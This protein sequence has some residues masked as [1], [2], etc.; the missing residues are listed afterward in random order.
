MPDHDRQPEGRAF[1]S[2]PTGP[3]VAAP[4][5]PWAAPPAPY[6]APPSPPVRKRRSYW[7]LLLFVL[8]VS[9]VGIR[10]YRDLSSPEAWSYWK[11]Q[12]V[13]PSLNAQPVATV[14]LDGSVRRV[15]ALAISGTIG[16]AAADWFRGQ[17][18][19]NKLAAGDVI[20]LSSPGGDLAQGI[21]IGEAIRARGLNTAVG[22]ID[23][24]GR[25]RAAY[26]ASACVFAYAGGKVRYGVAGS[27]LGVH[28]FTSRVAA[29]D[30]VADAQRVTGLVLNY[31]TRMGVASTVVEA[32][33][34]TREIRW[35]GAKE[36]AAMQLITHPLARP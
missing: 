22:T 18:D 3:R 10:A 12:Y 30:P 16:A 29:N 15:R 1:Q 24:S 5:Q 28:Q 6:P 32:M 23:G 9:S 7:S 2:S 8:V 27:G 31:M 17:I 13:S 33:S 4:H 34:Q 14:D 26:C 19:D 21:L 20:L 11:D 35:L 25:I 36:A